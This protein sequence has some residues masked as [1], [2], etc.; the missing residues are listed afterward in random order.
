MQD[1]ETATLQSATPVYVV[2]VTPSATVVMPTETDAVP[3]CTPCDAPV[4][5]EVIL[6][7]ADALA[8]L[9]RSP[10]A[11]VSIAT[12]TDAVA[13]FIASAETVHPH[14]TETLAEYGLAGTTEADTD[15]PTDA[16]PT[17]NMV[18]AA[19]AS[20]STDTRT[21]VSPSPLDAS[22]DAIYR[23]RP[24]GVNRSISYSQWR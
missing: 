12:P 16:Y 8:L 13:S 14:D 5:S 15:I 7:A 24:G 20:I 6:I 22:V 21:T 3:S 18:A 2:P 1:V 17:N 23:S 9:T 19:D 4:H 10:D 11:A